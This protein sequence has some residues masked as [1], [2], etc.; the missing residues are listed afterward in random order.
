MNFETSLKELKEMIDDAKTESFEEGYRMGWNSAIRSFDRDTCK[1][2]NS[3]SDTSSAT[4]WM[5]MPEAHEKSAKELLDDMQECVD[6]FF[7]TIDDLRK[8]I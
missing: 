6:T 3:P 4:A 2:E 8:K 1:V 5:D 7:A